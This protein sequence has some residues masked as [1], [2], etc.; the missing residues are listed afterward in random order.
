MV[1]H[2]AGA[3]A[4]RPGAVRL[5]DADVVVTTYGLLAR[6]I[7]AL[8][9][10]EWATVVLDEAQMVKNAGTKAAKAVRRLRAGQKLA[11]TGTPVENRLVR[12]VVDPRRRQSRAARQP[13]A[14]PRAVREA[15]RAQRRR[16]GG[17]RACAR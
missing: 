15:D 13:A 5:A 10:V 3:A 2:G 7:D 9:A 12:A 6:D 17:G 16:R 4:G 14:I 1:H 11:L 8:S